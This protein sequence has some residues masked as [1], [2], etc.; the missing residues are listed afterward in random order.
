MAFYFF[1]KSRSVLLN[2]QIMEQRRMDDTSVARQAQLKRNILDL[3]RILM[4]AKDTP[5]EYSVIQQQLYTARL[6]QDIFN[7]KINEKNP[8]YRKGYFD[9]TTLTIPAGKTKRFEGK[10]LAT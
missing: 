6:E 5:K 3:E 2:D 7:K 10:K 1:E 9:T 4:Q 8:V